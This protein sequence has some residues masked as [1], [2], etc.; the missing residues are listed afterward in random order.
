MKKITDFIASRRAVI[1]WTVFYIAAMWCIF[2]V[3]FNFDIFSSHQWVHLCHAELRGFAGFTFGIM[4]LAAAPL[5][6]ATAVI[7]ARNNAFMFTVPVP[8]VI[9][10]IIEM[11]TPTPIAPEP[12]TTSA[13]PAATPSA[14]DNAT[15]ALPDGLPTELRGAF[16]RA[17]SGIGREQFSSFNMRSANAS[18]GDA[19]ITPDTTAPGDLPLPTDFDL[20]DGDT[21]VADDMSNM[22]A[23]VFTEINFDD[24]AD[25]TSDDVKMPSTDN[26]PALEYLDGKNIPVVAIDNDIIITDKFAIATHDDAAFWVA[27]DTNWFASGKTKPSP[28][29]AVRATA[30]AHNVAPVMYIPQ[31][32]I[33]DFDKKR[34]QWESD[35][36]MVITNLDEL[37]NY[38][39]GKHQD[40]ATAK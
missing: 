5:Y 4:I 23:P 15:S 17:R 28:I 10:R 6:I 34:E 12:A 14:P 32:N 16:L 11:M 7:T 27:D 8:G 26:S 22:D 30:D 31:P 1:I 38:P 24:D 3:M 20:G 19:P 40:I 35:G 39:R 25:D 18:S 37:K 21:P 13:E 9:K 33:M 29:V 36:I 2:R